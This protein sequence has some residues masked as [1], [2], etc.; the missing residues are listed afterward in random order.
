MSSED[1]KA[2]VTASFEMIFNQRQADRAGEFYAPDYLDHVAAPG[3]EGA[4]QKWAA[5]IAAA[6]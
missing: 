2:I 4:K 1:N 6:R 5:Y 3:L